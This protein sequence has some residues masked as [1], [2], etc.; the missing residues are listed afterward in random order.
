MNISIVYN[1]SGEKFVELKQGSKC[2]AVLTEE[3]A[4]ELLE[5]LQ[6]KYKG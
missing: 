3:E 1:T 2:I 6:E 5:Q 4:L